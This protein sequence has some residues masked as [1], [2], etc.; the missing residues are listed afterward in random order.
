MEQVMA[1]SG[2]V[3]DE[4]LRERWERSLVG[5]T[6][7]PVRRRRRRSERARGELSGGLWQLDGNRLAAGR[8]GRRRFV[9]SALAVGAALL[10]SA[11]VV[12]LAPAGADS[13]GLVCPAGVTASWVD[14][15]R[16][17]LGLHVP[18]P[19]DHLEVAAPTG[20]DVVVSFTDGS[21]ARYPGAAAAVPDGGVLVV[22]PPRPVP[23]DER[24]QWRVQVVVTS[25]TAAA[26]C[27]GPLR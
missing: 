9:V 1:G 17:V 10:G 11:S 25:G 13:A 12:V 3:R 2:Q 6:G 8:A 26:V 4:A 22:D 23:A 5:V 20:S 24:A 16:D 19:R 15:Y 14:R 18:D 27:A 21:G 7:S